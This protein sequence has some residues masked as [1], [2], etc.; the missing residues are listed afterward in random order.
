MTPSDASAPEVL[1]YTRTNCHLCEQVKQQL[2]ELQKEI[3][4]QFQEVDIDED[5]GLRQRYNEEVPVV[6]VHGKKAFK[7]RV[8][9]RQFLRRLREGRRTAQGRATC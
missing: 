6:M 5:D 8:D 3:S 4:F 1:L 9:A 7:Y 2:R